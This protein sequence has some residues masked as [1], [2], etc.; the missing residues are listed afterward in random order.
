MR[1]SES[2]CSRYRRDAQLESRWTWKGLPQDHA[3]THLQRGGEGS[4]EAAEPPGPQTLSCA[5]L[6]R[7]EAG[8]HHDKQHLARHRDQRPANSRL[9]SPQ[10]SSWRTTQARKGREGS[11]SAPELQIMAFRLFSWAPYPHALP[12]AALFNAVPL[13]RKQKNPRNK[14][15]PTKPKKS[16]GESQA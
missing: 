3:E 14:T 2:Q 8:W 13:S 10:Q 16:P 6:R 7:G 4:P 15:N 5:G 1:L 12:T 11:M 9:H